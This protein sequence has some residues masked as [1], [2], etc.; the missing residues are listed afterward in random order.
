MVGWPGTSPNVVSAGGTKVNRVNNNFTNETGWSGSGGGPSAYELRPSY[1]DG[2][3]GIVGNKRGTPDFSYDADPASGVSVYNTN[4]ACGNIQWLKVGGTSVSSPALAGIVNSTG[5]FA[6]ST[7]VENTLIYSGLGNPA[8]F[9]DI[10]VGQAGSHQAG[11]GWDFV[12]G[13]G[14]DKG[15][16][17][18]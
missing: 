11:P 12:T 1:Q 5:G 9:T 10:T 4:P 15:K 18:K 7:S 16:T 13:V 6:A 17:G 3:A 14:T 2:I 8:I